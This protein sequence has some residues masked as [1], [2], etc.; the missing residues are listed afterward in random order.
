M[1]KIIWVAG[2]NFLYCDTDSVKYLGDISEALKKYN[3]EAKK[4][5]KNNRASATDPAGHT[6][7]MG[8]FEDDG[9]YKRFICLGAK[10]YAYEDDDGNLHITVAGVAKKKGAVE[11]QKAGGLEA[12]KTGLVFRDAGGS[13]A[14]YN[15]RANMTLII[16][17]HE[18]YIGPNLC[19][20]PS[21]YTLKASSFAMEVSEDFDAFFREPDIIRQLIHERNIKN[22][23]SA[24]GKNNT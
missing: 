21:T 20:R 6:H 4:R 5:S 7:Y 8:V 9:H 1:Q 17:G 3:R 12:F 18:L 23:L 10:K 22:T 19:L 2:D 16:D 15:D 14:V 13:D 24:T 11:L